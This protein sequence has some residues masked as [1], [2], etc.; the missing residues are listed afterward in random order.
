MNTR[1]VLMT[2]H[3]QC[4]RKVTMCQTLNS[5]LLTHHP[6]QP[7]SPSV[8]GPLGNSLIGAVSETNFPAGS[9]AS[10]S[11]L[12]HCFEPYN[13]GVQLGCTTEPGHQHCPVPCDSKTQ[14][15]HETILTDHVLF[16][17]STDRYSMNTLTHRI[18][19]SM[20]TWYLC[21]TWIV[22]MLRNVTAHVGWFE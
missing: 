7:P 20:H 19:G 4:W 3:V 15:G 6:G 5:S 12:P 22:Q 18:P 11:C 1:L 8:S 14:P 10:W 13:I 17:L 16:L 9:W 2:N 21:P